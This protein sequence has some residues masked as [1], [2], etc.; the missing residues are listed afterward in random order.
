MTPKKKIR[1]GWIGFGFVFLHCAAIITY[2]MPNG[3]LPVKMVEASSYYVDPIFPQKWSMFAPC[4]LL[5]HHVEVKYTY[6]NGD[7]T[8]WISPSADAIDKHMW[9]RGS[10]HGDLAVAEYN[11]LYWV[12]ARIVELDLQDETT[13][14]KDKVSDFKCGLGY[15]L[16]RNYAYGNSVYLFDKEPI[17]AYMKCDFLNVKTGKARSL[18]LPEFTWSKQ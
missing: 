6:E 14:P 7:T 16:A 17:S 18:I 13:V 11:T 5:S 15:F 10:H 1:Y 4:P 12:N 9:I 2:A 3:I 8:D